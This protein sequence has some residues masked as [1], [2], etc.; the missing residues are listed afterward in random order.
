VRLSSGRQPE[1]R[2]SFSDIV[3]YYT[4]SLA[5]FF[6]LFFAA[7]TY[8]PVRSHDCSIAPRGL[9]LLEPGR[10]AFFELIGQP[11]RRR[12]DRRL[13][14]PIHEVAIFGAFLLK[15]FAG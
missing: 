6:Y 8:A 1:G 10:R 13:K 3:N 5:S 4:T 11:V 9:E 2:L 12:V 7:T 14:L 15:S